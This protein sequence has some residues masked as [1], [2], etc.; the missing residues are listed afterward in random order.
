MTKKIIYVILLLITPYALPLRAMQ[1]ASIQ[2]SPARGE[3][4]LLHPRQNLTCGENVH[5]ALAVTVGIGKLMKVGYICYALSEGLDSIDQGT[6]G[7]IVIVSE[8]ALGV[9]L[10]TYGCSLLKRRINR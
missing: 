1:S 9:W 3:D 10:I 5:G 8:M 2:A 6:Q 4:L 7:G